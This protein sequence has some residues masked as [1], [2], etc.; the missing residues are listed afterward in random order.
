M[1]NLFKLYFVQ[2]RETTIIGALGGYI[3]FLVTA[4]RGFDFNLFSIQPGLLEQFTSNAQTLTTIQA[5]KP[6]LVFILLGISIAF[7]IRRFMK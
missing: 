5:I 4:A 2:E 3:S 7:I 1:V 6:A